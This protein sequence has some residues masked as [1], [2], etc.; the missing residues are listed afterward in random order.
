[1]FFSLRIIILAG[2]N[3]TYCYDQNGNMLS[4]DGRAIAYSPF[5][6]PVSIARPSSGI[7]RDCWG[8]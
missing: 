2:K 4:G 5:D 7:R 6:M 3:A 1:M 8:A